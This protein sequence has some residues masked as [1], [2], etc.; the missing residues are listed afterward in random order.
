MYKRKI[1]YSQHKKLEE[2]KL[3]PIAAT[4]GR[5]FTNNIHFI[6]GTNNIQYMSMYLI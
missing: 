5:W 2:G 1:I 6:Q 3:L 4:A